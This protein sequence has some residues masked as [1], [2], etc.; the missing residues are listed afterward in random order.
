[1]N[2][3]KSYNESVAATQ[4]FYRLFLVPGGSHCA[5]NAAEVNGP[6]P[7][8]TLQNLID[9]V[10]KDVAPT[11]LN[12][13]VLL[14][15][16]AGQNQQI[17][18]WPLRPIFKDNGTNLECVYDQKSIDSWKYDLDAFDMPVY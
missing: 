15:P 6:W 14:G 1:M 7:Q 13:T 4:E 5:P 10:E 16:N 2:P 9:W 11:T 18:G 12:G 3:G 17:C 8:T